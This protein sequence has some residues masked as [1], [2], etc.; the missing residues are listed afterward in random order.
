MTNSDSTVV[1][2]RSDQLWREDPTKTFSDW[3]IEIVS[4]TEADDYEAIER[5]TTYHV[6]K[7]VLGCGLRRSEYFERL[8]RN[9]HFR[10]AESSSSRIEL[11]PLAADAFPLL[12][13]YVYGDKHVLSIDCNSATAVHSL[14]DYF[15]MP[16]LCIEALQFVLADMT[17]ENVV[18]Y[19]NHAVVLS[20]NAIHETVA[21]FL[22]KNIKQN[23]PGIWTTLANESAPRLWQEV[24][25]SVDCQDKDASYALSNL[26]CKFATCNMDKLDA[27]TFQDLTMAHTMPHV[28]PRAAL[29]LWELEDAFCTQGKPFSVSGEVGGQEC[30]LQARCE[31][32]LLED[33]VMLE[34]LL[35]DEVTVRGFK[36]GHRYPP[37]LVEVL[38]KAL[39]KANETAANFKNDM[40]RGKIEL[41]RARAQLVQR[42]YPVD[43]C[44]DSKGWPIFAKTQ[45]I[46][47]RCTRSTSTILFMD[48]K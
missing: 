33:P 24:S 8:F 41:E 20:N 19:Y 35:A 2:E 27:T 32:S 28:C 36:M 34:R 14:G 22:G 25:K 7:F 40:E 4:K 15:E 29:G 6:H 1:D 26:I 16:A 39:A 18:T 31:S 23:N 3:T 44:F 45:I 12:L 37:Y 10:E 17:L 42:E 5:A 30:S 11:D 47:G 38:V 46:N 48:R 43:P 21:K 13:D 9:K